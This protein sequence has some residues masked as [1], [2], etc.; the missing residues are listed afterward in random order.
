MEQA[1]TSVEQ[2]VAQCG[3]R[4]CVLH[5]SRTQGTARHD[6]DYDVAVLTTPG[7]GF[8][9]VESHSNVLELASEL[10]RVSQDRI[11]IAYLDHANPLLLKQ[12][13]DHGK[14]LC[15]TEQDFLALK[16]KAFHRYVDYQP[17]FALE[18]ALNREAFLS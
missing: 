9:S 8:R 15:G 14:L 18:R 4:L 5:G 3:V 13:A 6:S 11:D 17:C 2:R 1:M 16:L 7:E 10:L 12:V